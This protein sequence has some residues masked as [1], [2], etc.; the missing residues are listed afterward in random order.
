MQKRKNYF[1]DREFQTKF[2]LKFC[3]INIAASVL[4]GALIYFLN[5]QSKTVAFEDLKV[6]V[7]STSDFLFPIMTQVLVIVAAFAAITT[8]IIVL[9]TSHRIA[10]PLY[11]LTMDF[12]RLKDKDLSQ[13]IKIRDHDQLQRLATECEALRVEYL[14]S[15]RALSKHWEFIEPQLRRWKEGVSDPA[16][17]KRLEERLRAFSSE[18]SQFKT[19]R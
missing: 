3:L 8:T 11:H 10:G 1:I 16:E 7:K 17:K 12:K 6:V 5:N 4:T 9:F 18:L 13:P 14:Q 19:E 15:F 2:I